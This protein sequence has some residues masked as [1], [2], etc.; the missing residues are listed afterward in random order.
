MVSLQDLQKESVW[1]SERV[2]DSLRN[3]ATQIRRFY[4]WPS[5]RIGTIGDE[6]HL[7]GYHRSRDWI[8]ESQHCTNRGYS[9]TE[10]DGNRFGGN[11]YHIAGMDI[12]TNEVHARRIVTDLKTAKASGRLRK[13]REIVL[14]FN[15]V[16]VHLGFDRGL[17]AADHNDIYNLIVGHTD[18]DERMIQLNISLPEL[19]EG[20]EGAPVSKWQTLLNFYGANIKVDGEFGPITKG[21]TQDLQAKFGAESIDGIVG[22]ETWCIGI[23]GE[24]QV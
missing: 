8:R 11:G 20:S 22:P 14:E 3:L 16:H 18:K 23:A 17:V 1:N 13:L 4:D 12:I 10:S 15:P 19:H 21:A 7:K 6:H 9:V 24:D 2:P 5:W